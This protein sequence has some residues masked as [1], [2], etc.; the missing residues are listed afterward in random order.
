MLLH[1]KTME[2]IYIYMVFLVFAGLDTFCKTLKPMMGF[3]NRTKTLVNMYVFH[4]STMKNLEDLVNMYGFHYS[5]WEINENHTYL[6]SFLR[7][8]NVEQ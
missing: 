5:A 2:N 8:F 1:R 7:F 3:F 4:W 6:H